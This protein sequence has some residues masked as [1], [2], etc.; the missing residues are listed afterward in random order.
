MFWDDQVRYD[1]DPEYTEVGF[2]AKVNVGGGA[3]VTVAVAGREFPPAPVQV[4]V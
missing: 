2:A 1:D 4:M 3:M